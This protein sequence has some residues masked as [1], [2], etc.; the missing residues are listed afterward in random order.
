MHGDLIN[1]SDNGYLLLRKLTK[2]QIVKFILRYLPYGPQITAR[3]KRMF[4]ITNS[5]DRKYLPED[6]IRKFADTQFANGIQ[7][8][9][10][11]HF[12]HNYHYRNIDGRQ[13]HVLP[14]WASTGQVALFEPD[15]GNITSLH[16]KQLSQRLSRAQRG[17]T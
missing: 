11:G 2:N 3:I 8:I 14:D 15:S 12:H 6:K 5:V 4:E 17:T 1:N 9:V 13:L 10:S 16:W 7:T